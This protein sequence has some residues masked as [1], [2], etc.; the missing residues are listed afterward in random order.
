VDRPDTQKSH[1]LSGSSEF[2]ELPNV[3]FGSKI[4]LWASA[5]HMY[6]RAQSWTEISAYLLVAP[7]I[8]AEFAEYMYA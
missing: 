4:S 7:R 3:A 8:F 2:R 6:D 5:V 1:Q